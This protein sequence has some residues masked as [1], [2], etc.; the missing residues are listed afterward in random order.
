MALRRGGPA[1]LAVGG[2]Q[3]NHFGVGMRTDLAPAQISQYRSDGFC[4][5]PDFLDPAELEQ[6]R[7]ALDEAV[8]NRAGLK[9]PTI[10]DQDPVDTRQWTDTNPVASGP[11]TQRLQ[12]WRTHEHFRHVFLDPALGKMAATLANVSAIRIW[13]DQT[14]IKEPWAPPSSFHLDNP[15]WSFHHPESISIWVALDDVDERNGC[16]HFIPGSQLEAVDSVAEYPH[17]PAGQA[18]RA[19]ASHGGT[20]TYFERYPEWAERDPVA[21]VMKAG[22]ATFHNGLTLHGAGSNMTPRRRRAMTCAFMPDGSIFN[23]QQNVLPRKYF[24]SLKLGDVL[25]NDMLNPLTWRAHRL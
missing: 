3:P 19:S 18:T 7:A 9:L 12:L 10:D 25:D 22:S 8:D 11:Y 2:Q 15:L 13:H 5:V 4:T 24:E 21:V 14:L 16:M 1:A 6:W 17:V 23:G 20:G